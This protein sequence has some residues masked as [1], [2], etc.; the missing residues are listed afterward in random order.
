MTIDN[1]NKFQV[2]DTV[3]IT[4]HITSDD[5]ETFAQ[6]TGDDNPLHMDEEYAKTTS[7]K[8]RVVHGML[9][10]SFISTIIGTKIPGEGALWTSQTLNFHA[11]ARINDVITVKATL[12]QKSESQR[13]FLLGIEVSNQDKR[14]LITGESK[15]KILAATKEVVTQTENINSPAKYSTRLNQN[16]PIALVT[17]ASNGIGAEIAKKLASDGFHV[18]INYNSSKEK[19]ENLQQEI[20]NKDQKASIFQANICNETEVSEMA[21]IIIN[22]I[23]HPQVI[24]NN[25]GRPI[26]H[27]TFSDLSWEDIQGHIDVQLKGSYNT[28][29]NFLPFMEQQERGKIINIISTLI[30]NVPPVKIYDYVLSKAALHSFSKSL[31]VEFGPKNIHVNCVSPGMTNTSLIANLP[32]RVKM[33][34]TMQTPLRRLA[35]PFEIANVVSF[36][37]SSASDYLTGETIRVCGGQSMY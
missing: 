11:P 16:N 15:V 18:I 23:G 13:I 31:A 7:F 1:F 32:E 2:G 29:K 28:C 26:I 5:V 6:L 36:L 33:V 25:A 24:V 12:N 9:S 17:G 8:E 22:E 37:A 20:I 10:A 27:K 14:L 35:E 34:A 21:S 3:T 30:D 4:H 19:A